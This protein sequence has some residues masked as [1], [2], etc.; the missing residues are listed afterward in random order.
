MQ[1]ASQWQRKTRE[2]V[3]PLIHPHVL[4]AMHAAAYSTTGGSCGDDAG[5]DDDADHCSTAGNSMQVAD[6]DDDPEPVEAA[7]PSNPI[8]F[9]SIVRK[10]MP[11]PKTAP[12]HHYETP[13]LP[14]PRS[15]DSEIPSEASVRSPSP[16]CD[17]PTTEP[18]ESMPPTPRCE[19][20]QVHRPRTADV[21]RTTP[22]HP[23]VET[24]MQVTPGLE[25]TI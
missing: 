3:M 10:G 7:E 13:F 25:V 15:R 24:A 18:P 11:V 8:P 2:T 14:I 23:S 5:D 4:T 20:P 21:C 6:D 16:R 22:L 1:S 17:T 9:Q 19:K 12:P